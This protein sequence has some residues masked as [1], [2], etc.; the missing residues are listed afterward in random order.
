MRTRGRERS[1]SR[2]FTQ[3][4]SAR[5]I[6]SSRRSSASRSNPIGLHRGCQRSQ[7]S[8]K[9][10]RKVTFL[11]GTDLSSCLRILKHFPMTFMIRRLARNFSSRK[12]EEDPVLTLRARLPGRVKK[13]AI[14]FTGSLGKRT[15]AASHELLS[16]S[17]EKPKR[18]T[19]CLQMRRQTGF[20]SEKSLR[21]SP[22]FSNGLTLI[23]TDKSQA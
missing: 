22:K 20:C 3:S 8:S 5:N 23:R 15:L 19:Q 12:W 6:P 17:F 7:T 4:A 13:P 14:T 9:D 21:R 1:A 18:R 11:K 2:R 10:C 16:G